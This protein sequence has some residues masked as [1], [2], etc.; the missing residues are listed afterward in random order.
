MLLVIAAVVLVL[1]VPLA[2]GS[3][4]RLAGLNI[5]ASWTV[6]L[7][8]AIQVG[9]TSVIRGG[10]HELHVLLHFGSYALVVWFLIAN[11]RIFG[12]PLL[13]LGAA[14]NILAIAAN[15]GTMP[16]SA[17]ALRVSGID[18]SGGFENSGLVAHS[19]LAF[20]GDIIPVPGPWPI[21]NVLSIGDLLIYT[22]GFIVLHCACQSRLALKR[23]R[24]AHA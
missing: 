24:L 17:F 5:R 4:K 11:R 8:A 20:L 12:M 18:T 10:S 6:L 23:R 7:S 9:I 14:L 1:S 19:H 16:A 22:G 21:G 2:G 13:A 3:L 15:N